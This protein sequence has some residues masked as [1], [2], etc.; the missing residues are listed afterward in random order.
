[1][2]SWISTPKPVKDGDSVS[3]AV[4]TEVLKD[5][6]SRD[7]Y[8]FEKI[9]SLESKSVLVA[10]DQQIDENTTLNLFDVVYM[11]PT[12]L[13]KAK[14]AFSFD[15]GRGSFEAADSSRVY[16]V[17]YQVDNTSKLADLY[18]T[19]LVSVNNIQDMLVTGET[20]RVGPYYLS[21]TEE[22]KLTSNP[23]GFAVYVG[24]CLD[25]EGGVYRRI[26]LQPKSADLVDFFTS[27][28]FELL[29][30]PACTPVYD[31]GSDQWSAPAS[32][33]EVLQNVGWIDA[34][35][36]PGAPTGASF[37]YNIP[38]D[39]A[40]QADNTLSAEQKAAA[41][42]LRKSLPPDPNHNAIF[43]VNGVI[44]K[45][46]EG[47]D[48]KFF[49]NSAGI[50][51]FGNSDGQQPWASDLNSGAPGG[52]FELPEWSVWKG[53]EYLRPKQSIFF[54]RF[55]PD[56]KL[57]LVTSL[58]VKPGSLGRFVSKQNPNSPAQAGDLLLELL[59]GVDSTNLTPQD[60]VSSAIKQIEIGLDGRFKVRRGGV[61]TGLT[62]GSGIQVSVNPQ[63]GQAVVT[64]TVSGLEG[65]VD[66]LE[67]VNARFEF[68]GLN[69]YLNLTNPAT[70]MTGF[71][72]KFKLP[73]TIPSGEDLQFRLV[74]FTKTNPL[75]TNAAFDFASRVTKDGDTLVSSISFVTATVD[76]EAA[77]NNAPAAYKQFSIAPVVMSIPASQLSA[78]A[79]VN[80]QIRRKE[81]GVDPYSGDIGVLGVY[82]S[83]A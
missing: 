25:A 45:F 46:R 30:R 31:S 27:F 80:F 9:Q 76:L 61:V 71:S 58:G 51:W 53:S 5:Y 19:G 66:S 83:F 63:T 16:G 74:L 81:P 34:S 28:K 62:G 18:V 23:G 3:S 15:E 21:G 1:M 2:T 75:S 50:W 82:W 52:S 41:I 22:G 29:D 10:L 42:A 54:N 35:L 70:L 26:L 14:S 56:F 12:G 48:G 55:N 43:S 4:M 37:K 7:Q 33:S 40:V 59:S 72:G 11:S 69:S 38:A 73:A 24:Y 65:R 77:M 13:K 17:V 32:P 68:F 78:D 8:L 60:E 79:V 64:S 47:S 36:S 49:I 67:P 6:A 39:A 57:L 20:P 44:Q